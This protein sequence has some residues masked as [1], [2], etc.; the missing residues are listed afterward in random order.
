[1][2]FSI[3]H[4]FV[5]GKADG[6]DATQIRKTDWNA[7]HVHSVPTA[8][9]LGNNSG[10]TGDVLALAADEVWSLMGF[11][12]DTTTPFVQTTPPIGW[13][14]QTTHN[15]KALRLV[16]GTPSSGGTTAFTSVFSAGAA[17]SSTTLTQAHMGS[18][19]HTYSGTTNTASAHT[20]TYLEPAD[21]TKKPASTESGSGW[22]D[23]V[24][25]TGH[26]SSSDGAHSHTYTGTASG[27]AAATGHSHTINLA[28]KY[29]DIVY[30]TKD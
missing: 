7:A 6:S 27:G 21:R 29:V 30:A 25:D 14:K 15:N 17:T 16:S 18:H 20:H 10:S 11:V 4:T 28:V 12:Q 13:T 5:S 8:C 3:A 23:A 19:S 24:G 2:A 1:M 9:V 22:G 26:T